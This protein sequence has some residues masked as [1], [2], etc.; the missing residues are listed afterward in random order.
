M[1]PLAN[2]PARVFP[3]EWPRPA[4]EAL[5]EER[6]YGLLEN[7][8]G[9]DESLRLEAVN[10]SKLNKPQAVE[11][12]RVYGWEGSAIGNATSSSSEKDGSL[13]KKIEVERKQ[14]E[15]EG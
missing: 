1:R 7:N 2:I 11:G 12:P 5:I 9:L 13:E 6:K 8:V 15:E 3:R 4:A 14:E 10:V